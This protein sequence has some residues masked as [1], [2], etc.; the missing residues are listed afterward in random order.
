MDMSVK[1]DWKLCRTYDDA[2]DY[3][4]VIYLHEWSGKP[5]YWGV[6]NKS[7]FGG[8]RQKIENG[9][10]NPRYGSSYKHWIEGCL[11]HGAILYIGLIDK[12]SGIELENIEK[13]LIHDFPSEM[14]D[15]EKSQNIIIEHLGDVPL[16]VRVK[17]P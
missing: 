13:Q 17:K 10:L 3:Q 2:K 14:N 12:S 16:S 4:Q 7:K 1:I 9:H 15:I 8:N 6:A 11:R 5:F